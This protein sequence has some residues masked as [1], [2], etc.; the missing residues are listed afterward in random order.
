M[1][2]ETKL[3]GGLSMSLL[4]LII[5]TFYYLQ[6][7]DELK[8]CQTDKSYISGGDIQKAGM[9]QTIDS[10]QMELFNQ[11]T[12]TGRYEIALEILKEKDKKAADLYELILTTQTE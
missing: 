4:G 11:Q 9:Q 1:T 10:L 5:M 8:K 3:R 12:I 7:Q 6:Q 2:T